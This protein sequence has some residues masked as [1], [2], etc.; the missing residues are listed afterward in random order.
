MVF[1]KGKNILL[2]I[3]NDGIT[4]LLNKEYSR[5]GSQIRLP[6]LKPKE[7][8]S[9]NLILAVVRCIGGTYKTCGRVSLENINYVNQSAEL[10][11][12]V[13]IEQRKKGIAKEACELIIKH[14]FDELNLRRIDCGTLDTNEGMKKLADSLGF[15]EEGRRKEAVYKAGK[16]VDVVEYGLLKGSEVV[17]NK[18][19]V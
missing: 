9:N 16:F 13:D 17:E 6:L 1:I 14:G 7:N 12:F 19:E 10:K 2:N 5:E 11:I 15:K 8:D 3:T 4:E 18:S